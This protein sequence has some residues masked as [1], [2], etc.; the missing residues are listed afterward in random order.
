MARLSD[1]DFENWI[2]TLP[3][4]TLK[5]LYIESVKGIPQEKSSRY[6]EFQ[7]EYFYDFAGFLL[8]CVDWGDSRPTLYQLEIADA[9]L[10]NERYTIRGPRGLGK[11][12]IASLVILA[13]ALTREGLDWK[14][15]TTASN[16][17]QLKNFLW[18]E[19]HKW[20][21]RLKWDV[22]G[23]EPFS[24]DELLEHNLKLKTGRAFAL[25]SNKKVGDE[26]GSMEGSHADNMLY[27]FDEAKNIADGVFDSAEGSFTAGKERFVFVI[28]TPGPQMGR[29][30]DIHS[31]A[32]GYEDWTVRWI[33]KN[34]AIKAGRMLESWASD[35]EKQWGK[36][37]FRY[38]NDVEGD[39]AADSTSSI[40]PLS[41]VG[42]ANAAYDLWHNK[43]NSNPPPA[44]IGCD[45]AAS[46][47]D[48]VLAF[49]V[50]PVADK[51]YKILDEL[52]VD[53]KLSLNQRKGMEALTYKAKSGNDYET[54]E[55]IANV[56]QILAY[57]YNLDVTL[58]DLTN[59]LSPY[60]YVSALHLKGIT[61][62]DIFK[63]KNPDTP[64]M[65]IVGELKKYLDMY[66]ECIVAVDSIGVGRGVANRLVELGY[67]KRTINFDVREKTYN[68]AVTGEGF[69]NK[70]AAMWWLG[71]ETLHP[72]NK[73]G[74]FLPKN[75]KLMAELTAVKQI[76]HTSANLI[77]VE[78]K[79][80][81]KK[82][83][84]RSTDHA[85]AVLM[86]L[87]GS[88]LSTPSDNEV[89]DLAKYLRENS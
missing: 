36:L 8:D 47:D 86:A 83:L 63:K 9:I 45:V 79:K 88:T 51:L 56:A 20:S 73:N 42:R 50:L 1:K 46:V 41:F 52:K 44:Y 39:F 33:T 5:E 29:F 24:K 62:L 14:I 32:K 40:I 21:S 61:H 67:G 70:R 28:S 59:L 80:E 43:I 16:W 13:F 85:D 81:I 69:I 22:I 12:A 64:L 74:V 71:K 48:T 54:G 53:S 89:L 27:V 3:E 15:P 76:D 38:L 37:D 30:Y 57:A 58:R 66:P 4:D 55:L 19:I 65:Q 77:R 26:G 75:D 25:T 18:P 60:K 2:T 11:T 34:E 31:R 7:K 35:R 87:F 49:Y 84:G 68:K 6:E 72:D 10:E 82:R 23:R 78:S 17:G